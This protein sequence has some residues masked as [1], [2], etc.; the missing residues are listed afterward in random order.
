M[1]LFAA[2]KMQPRTIAAL[3]HIQRGVSGARWSEAEKLHITVG[4]FG[5]VDDDHAEEL[6]HE[7]ARLR[8]SSFDLSLKGVN[9][10]GK[11]E[12]HSLWAGVSPH[13]SLTRIHDHC[14][15]AARRVGIP[16]EKRK[17]IPHVTLAYLKKDASIDRIIRFEQ[18][19]ANFEAGP[20]LVDE[21]LLFSSWK[22]VRGPNVYRMEASYPL[23][24]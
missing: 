5:E 22:K 2:I 1:I 21:F 11:T 4:Y 8:L 3:T 9:H 17:F 24:G 20:F 10:F 7:L 6:D 14:R 15:V 18:R 13:P 19:L 16:M 12:P 23:L